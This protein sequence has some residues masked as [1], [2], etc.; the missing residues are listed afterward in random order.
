MGD[1]KVTRVWMK[2]SPAWLVSM[3]DR[4]RG[5]LSS[6]ITERPASKKLV[7]QRD[8][9]DVT[10]RGVTRCACVQWWPSDVLVPF[11]MCHLRLTEV[12][13]LLLVLLLGWLLVWVDCL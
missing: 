6:S 12:S 2:I 7:R 4:V 1:R 5:L 10:S 11:G 9:R 3:W 8:G 13:V